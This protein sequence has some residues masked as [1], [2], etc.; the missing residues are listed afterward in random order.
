MHGSPEGA[1][2]GWWQASDGNWYPPDPARPTVVATPKTRNWAKIVGLAA[3]VVM[4]A[5]FGAASLSLHA[6]VDR[7]QN[8]EHDQHARAD[9]LTA[10][11]T[12][13]QA[14][15]DSAHS[16]LTTSRSWSRDASAALHA[17]A[18]CVQDTNALFQRIGQDI[19]TN[20]PDPSLDREAL[21]V[22]NECDAALS[23]GTNVELP[24]VSTS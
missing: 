23:D 4:I 7:W 22:Q 3:V 18:T 5:G 9:K 16:D 21:R 1:G 24:P 10:D 14:Q 11:V 17:Y 13:T 6:S 12:S 2:A 20:N 8:R 15:L 19:A